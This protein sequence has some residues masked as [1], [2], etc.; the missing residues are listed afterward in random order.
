VTPSHATA[1]GFRDLAD[2]LDGTASLPRRNGE[3]VFEQPWHSRAFG[4]AIGLHKAGRFDW[5]DFRQRLIARI[6]EWEAG[7]ESF[8][9]V[10]GYYTHWLAALEDVLHESRLVEPSVVAGRA[11]ALAIDSHHA[12][13]RHEH[14]HDHHGA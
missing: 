11:A 13:G 1:A 2:R 7:D 12:H 14:E 3:I 9:G 4:M 8:D 5:E 6:A 10:Y